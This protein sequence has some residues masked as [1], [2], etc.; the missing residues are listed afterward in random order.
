MN[1]SPEKK[2]EFVKHR[3]DGRVM[4]VLRYI[5]LAGEEHVQCKYWNG[6]KYIADYFEK[7]E[8]DFN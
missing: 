4:I 6:E 2:P 1:S 8:L 5:E 7:I 3:L